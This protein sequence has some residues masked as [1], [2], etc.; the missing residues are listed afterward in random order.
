MCTM[1]IVIGLPIALLLAS[2][3][4]AGSRAEHPVNPVLRPVNAPAGASQADIDRA[5]LARFVGV[6]R[7]DGWSATPDGKRTSAS[8]H[9]AGVIESEHFVLLDLKTTSG[10]MGGRAGRKSGSMIFASEPGIGATLTAWGDAA[11][12]IT[13]LVGRV[14]GTGSAF[15]FSEAK[16]PK[17]RHR[18]T[19]LIT[20]ET[21][22]AW[23]AE[24]RDDTAG[25]SPVVASYRFTRAE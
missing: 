21:D 7:F 15:W 9:A 19:M 5:A 22:N 18:H 3:C 2:G 8:G 6:W 14:E 4:R 20:F 24:I 16:T 25:G 23:L 11:P 1:C 17:D 13:R 12:S 10:Q